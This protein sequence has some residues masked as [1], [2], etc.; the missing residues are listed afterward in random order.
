MNLSQAKLN[1][2]LIVKNFSTEENL[3]LRLMELGL[4]ESV[5]I[6][7]KHKSILKKNLLVV[8]NNSCF[9][10]NDEIAKTIEVEYV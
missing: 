2:N 8:F 1:T 4:Y 9:V 5:N 6:Y 7:V 10:I 3:K